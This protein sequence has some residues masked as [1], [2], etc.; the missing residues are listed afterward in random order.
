M[1]YE[2]AIEKLGTKPWIKL[3]GSNTC[4]VKKAGDYVAVKYHD[5]ELLT[6]GKNGFDLFVGGFYTATTKKRM[7]QYVPFGKIYQKKR[8][9]FYQFGDS[10]K[11]F[12]NDWMVVRN[13]E[14]GTVLIYGET[15]KAK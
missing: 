7:N 14:N 9:W 3:P 6:I 15:A 5:T 11:K 8:E 13:F 1:T 4:L 10:V 2:Q 12:S